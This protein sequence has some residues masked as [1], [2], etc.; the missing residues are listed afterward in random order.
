MLH[1]YD[2][3]LR[4]GKSETGLQACTYAVEIKTDPEDD[5]EKVY[6]ETP[7]SGDNWRLIELRPVSEGTTPPLLSLCSS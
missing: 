7:R 6:I 2:F 1:R 5:V 3:D 4:T